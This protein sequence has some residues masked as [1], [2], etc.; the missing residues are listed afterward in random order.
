M[1][2]EEK[3]M[4][5]V[6]AVKAS[7]TAGTI[8]TIQD[9][10]EGTGY[11]FT[12]SEVKEILAASTKTSTPLY[13]VEDAEWMANKLSVGDEFTFNRDLKSFTNANG[14]DTIIAEGDDAGL[15]EGRIAIFKTVG[16]TTSLDIAKYS[17]HHAE[18][19]EH[20]VHGRFKV[21]NITP[22]GKRYGYD[23]VIYEIKEL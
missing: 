22:G 4:G 14:I 16:P 11:K 1:E 8:S 15:Y 7:L 19:N 2:G 5:S 21:V 9:Y 3:I 20:L 6:G 18:E 10:I 23:T 17:V 13:R 12:Q